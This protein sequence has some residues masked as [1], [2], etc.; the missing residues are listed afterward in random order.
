MTPITDLIA[1]TAEEEK[2]RADIWRC[3]NELGDDN[4]SPVKTIAAQLDIPTA[5][6]ASV[7]YPPDIFGEWDDTQEPMP[8][9][10]LVG[11]D[12]GC[13]LI[14]DPGYLGRDFMDELLA[15]RQPDGGFDTSYL[16]PGTSGRS[17]CAVVGTD[18]GLFSVFETEDEIV[19]VTG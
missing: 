3:W 16:T 12:S 4:D 10:Q 6:V 2:R 5:L 19:V 14:I 1:M 11:V 18:D 7:V 15:H 17:I 13:L 8:R 9:S